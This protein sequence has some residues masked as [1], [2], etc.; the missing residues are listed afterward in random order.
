MV[1]ISFHSE[2]KSIYI[3]FLNK[4]NMDILDILNPW[5]KDGKVSSELA[6]AYRRE[7]FPVVSK[8]MAGKQIT[9]LSGLRR[10]GKST[11]MYQLISDELRSLG[12]SQRILY[13]SF[14][15]KV[16]D[17]FDVLERYS[18]LTG[19][20]WKKEKVLIFFDEIQKLED[21][22]SRLKLL[23]DSHPNL[24]IIVSGSAGFLIEK[25]FRLNLAGRHFLVTVS[26]L[27]FREFLELRNSKIDLSKQKLWE[28]EIK[29]EF[30]DYLLRPFPEIA[31]VNELSL[32]K[33][34][35]KSTIIDK[36]L[37][38]DLG[39][40]FKNLNESLLTSLLDL[41]FG[42]PGYY[43]NYDS[44]SKDLKVSKKTLMK[45]V[46]YL[47]FACL[48]RKINNYR[49]K[50]KTTS[51]K[52]QRLYPFH[53]SLEFG[54][55]GKISSE[56]IVASLLDAKNYWRKN[57][58]EVD[59]LL[60]GTE[61]VPVEVKQTAQPTREDFEN[62]KYFMDKFNAS[63]GALL[64]YNGEEKKHSYRDKTILALPFWKLALGKPFD[65]RDLR[66]H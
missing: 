24:K 42:N 62:L 57:G 18:G 61:L 66:I 48:A 26:P 23:Y 39:E 16:L 38:V 32:V 45:H 56:T 64:V 4:T 31:N 40:K 49:P 27:S 41:F 37:R 63:P 34:Y 65:D 52:L 30:E 5:W 15:E 55:T 59:F 3:G 53:F 14:D 51:R 7:V 11:I 1:I 12:N 8:L 2:T 43:L 33:S 22:S 60:A 58:R 17:V 50:Q 47:E 35:I 44:L 9:A 6:P 20:D 36:I 54:W 29:K 21:W 46:Y 28:P 13:F 25:D 10:T 19:I